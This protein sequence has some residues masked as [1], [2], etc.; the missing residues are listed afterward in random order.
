MPEID[1]RPS[2]IGARLKDVTRIV[3]VTAGKGGVGKSSIATTLAL[4]GAD[5]GKSVGLLDLDFTGPTDHV[6][7][8]AKLGFPS[9]EY[10]V[11]PERHSGVSF[12]SVAHFLGADAAALRGPDAT[13]AL[14]ELLAI[15]RWGALDTLVLDMPPGLGDTALDIH[16]YLPNA[17]HLI[18]ATPSQ[19]ARESVRRC[20]SLL[21]TQ[22]VRVLGIIENMTAKG[23]PTDIDAFAAAAG[24]P[25]LGS[26]PHDTHLEAALGTPSRV[27]ETA[28]GHTLGG[29]ATKL[30][31]L[32]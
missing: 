7:L 23:A 27:L 12:L 5:R 28:F 19:L 18:V 9:E 32:G 4:L 1:P 20:L 6:I 30:H 14:L 17:Q 16:R 31:L 13:N 8:G 29:I 26:L 15:A 22:R 11:D 25:Y 24:V 10:G 2:V 21:A 3:C